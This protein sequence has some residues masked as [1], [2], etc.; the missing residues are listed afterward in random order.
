MAREEQISQHHAAGSDDPEEPAPQASPT[1]RSEPSLPPGSGPP[2]VPPG[3]ARPVE[4][5]DPTGIISD[6]Q[7]DRPVHLIPSLRPSRRPAPTSDRPALRSLGP[8][9][10]PPVVTADPRAQAAIAADLDD[11]LREMVEERSHSKP[12][13]LP[14]GPVTAANLF[15]DFTQGPDASMAVRVIPSTPAPPRAPAAPSPDAPPRAL[16]QPPPAHP[17]QTRAEFL[18][19]DP[20]FEEADRDRRRFPQ[21]FMRPPAEEMSPRSSTD[22]IPRWIFAALLGLASLGI[23]WLLSR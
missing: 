12:F 20:S 15:D 21:D 11:S 3:L 19:S 2:L 14:P 9:S 4:F 13:S 16:A 7:S 8:P 18:S 22:P 5:D 6:R 23:W 17:P 10:R 1:A